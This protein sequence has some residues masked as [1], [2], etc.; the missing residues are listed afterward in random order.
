MIEC[1]AI[2]V[3]AAAVC[4]A[5]AWFGA[6]L[7]LERKE[8][9]ARVYRAFHQVIVSAPT[10]EERRRRFFV[11]RG[12]LAAAIGAWSGRIAVST[13]W[14]RSHPALIT[15]GVTITAAVAALMV[16]Q[17]GNQLPTT[18]PAAPPAIL[19]PAPSHPVPAPSGSAGTS[20][21]S[22]PLAPSASARSAPGTS[23]PGQLLALGDTSPAPGMA[24][25]APAPT[26]KPSGAPS[27]ATSPS[28]TSAPSTIT[29]DPSPTIPRR[30]CLLPVGSGPLHVGVCLRGT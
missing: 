26:T 29:I 9:R 1:I 21:P 27:T 18:L 2:V 13:W 15:S 30:R 10:P 25:P 4:I 7:W 14:H 3:A 17:L 11:I 6:G 16:V 20:V 23:V 8:S 28:P 19:T 5:A 12:G 22:M 24:T